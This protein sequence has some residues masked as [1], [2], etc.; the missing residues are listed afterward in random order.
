MS[1][2]SQ[3]TNTLEFSSR[4][5]VTANTGIGAVEGRFG[6]LQVM[7]DNTTFSDLQL[8]EEENVTILEALTY[9]RGDILYGQCT[10]FTVSAGTVTAH[11]Y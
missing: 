6:A 9:F 5:Q 11:A 1:G 3:R 2:Q 4:K 10:G 8:P 7:E